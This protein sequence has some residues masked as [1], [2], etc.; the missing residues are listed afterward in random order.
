MSGT[1]SCRSA[2][3]NGRSVPSPHS[4]CH[5]TLSTD[6]RSSLPL[7]LETICAF[8]HSFARSVAPVRL[9]HGSQSSESSAGG[10]TCSGDLFTLWAVIV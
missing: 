3:R 2:C 8:F 7:R 4:R 9:V 1:L 5:L 10:L 6:G